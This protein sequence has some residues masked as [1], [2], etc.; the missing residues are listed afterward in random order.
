[1]SSRKMTSSTRTSRVRRALAF[2]FSHMAMLTCL[3]IEQIENRRPMNP[4]MD[5]IYLLTPEPHIVDCL[6]ADLERRRYKRAFLIW[7]SVLD[8][9]HR[10]RI[11]E[12]PQNQQIIANMS[13]LTISYFPREARLVT[14][15]EPWSFPI[16]YHE[17]CNNLV[18]THLQSL[19]Q[20]VSWCTD[21]CIDVVLTGVDHRCVRKSRRIPGSEILQAAERDTRR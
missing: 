17:K 7:T 15:R 13:T 2:Y 1:M 18:A 21:G 11:M 12:S 6:M 14:F 16:L 9:K 20:K 10:M 8:G 5:A 4:E 19:A 3:D